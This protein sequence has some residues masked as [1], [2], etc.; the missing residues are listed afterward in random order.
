ML[1]EL[2]DIKQFAGEPRRR[3]F[4][5]EFFD[6]IIWQD[7]SKE[8]VGFEL[9]YDKSKNQ[10]A[11]RWEKSTGY[12]HYRVDDGDRP[13][14]HKACPVLLPDGHFDFKNIARLFFRESKM[15]EQKIAEFVYEKVSQFT[16]Y[17]DDSENPHGRSRIP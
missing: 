8:I 6:L 4:E 3:W 12:A 5:N 14:K 2:K 17:P 11:V 9:C 13:G 16:V 15:I 7:E 10:H 1:K